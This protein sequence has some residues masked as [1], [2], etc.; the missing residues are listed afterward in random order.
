MEFIKEIQRN[1]P[2]IH[3]VRNEKPLGACSAR[4]LAIFS[5]RGEF[6]TG[7]DD[8]DEFAPDRLEKFLNAWDDKYSFICSNFNNSYEDGASSKHYS[9]KKTEFTFHDLLI[10]NEASNQIF[11]RTKHLQSI[12]GFRVGVRRLQDWDTWIRL[13]HKHGSFLRIKEPL[14]V[15]HHDHKENESRVSRSYELDSALEALIDRNKDIYEEWALKV[16]RREIRSIRLKYSLNDLCEDFTYRKN[17]RPFLKY[18]KQYFV[19][20][21]G[22]RA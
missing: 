4:N 3:Y 18:A 5:A 2:K 17:F 1:N 16:L 8:D 10:N 11:T 19:K 21:F 13:S 22:R 9:D 14:Y 6:I 7:L 15:M 20:L 12:D